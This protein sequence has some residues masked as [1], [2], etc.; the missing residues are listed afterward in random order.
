MLIAMT[1]V[2]SLAAALS[3]AVV[4]AACGADDPAAE[5]A[6]AKPKPPAEKVDDVIELTALPSKDKPFRFDKR[7]LEVKAGLIEIRLDNQDAWT[8]NVRIQTGEKCCDYERDIGGTQSIT[9]PASIKGR[10]RLRPGTYWFVCGL[11]GHSDGDL[12]KQRGKLVVR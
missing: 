3:T 10:V 12:G 8:H 4:F 11:I 6:A 2:L 7:E 9:G 1:R 5:E